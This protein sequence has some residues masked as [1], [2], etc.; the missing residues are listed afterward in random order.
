[1][2]LILHTICTR[3]TCLAR[4]IPGRL[5]EDKDNHIQKGLLV[6][7]SFKFC[8]ILAGLDGNFPDLSLV[9]QIPYY[10]CDVSKTMA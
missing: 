2:K 4:C 9:G 5:K 1:M 6:T 10:A 3:A 8:N 7:Y